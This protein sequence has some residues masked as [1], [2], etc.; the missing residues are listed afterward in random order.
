MDHVTVTLIST[1]TVALLHTLI[2]SHWLC[3]VAV[4]KAHQW[5]VRKTLAVTAAAGTFHVV[6]TV[7]VGVGIILIGRQLTDVHRL[8]QLSAIVLLAIGL[9]YLVLHALH[10]GHRH[11]KDAAVPQ[12]MAIAALIFSVTV[13]P[14]AGAIPF[15]VAAAAGHW[16][17]VVLVAIVL[18]V[19]TLGN[20][21]LLVGL[22][23]LGIDKLKFEFIERYEKLLVGGLLCLLG[24]G[25]LVWPHSH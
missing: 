10:A 15:L 11:E 17:T 21:L 1:F 16:M 19:T 9:F 24:I 6:S 4:G 5:R 12:R 20:M 3:F 23:S 7:G 22:T 8:E 2:P 18:L 13:S 25:I 14:C